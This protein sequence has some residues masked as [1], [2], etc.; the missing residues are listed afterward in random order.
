MIQSAAVIPYLPGLCRELL[1][2]DLALPSVPTRWA[3]SPEAH[4][5]A[6][7]LREPTVIKRALRFG[8]T[9]KPRFVHPSDRA[10]TEN[11]AQMLRE[12]PSAYVT[13]RQLTLSHAPIFSERGLEPRPMALRLFV[14]ASPDGY[15]VMP[16][17]LCRFAADVTSPSV[18]FAS[19]TGSKDVWVTSETPV[20]TFSL[21][22]RRPTPL[23]LQRG[24]FDLPSRVADNLYWLGRYVERAEGHARLL[25][26]AVSRYTDETGE[27][28]VPGLPALINALIQAKLIDGDQLPQ[29]HPQQPV[30]LP[31]QLDESLT[32][33][34]FEKNRPGSL[35]A[36]LAAVQRVASIVRDRLSRDASRMLGQVRDPVLAPHRG[37]VLELS[38]AA[39]TLDDLITRLAAFSG[40][41]MESMNRGMGW[42]FMDIGRRVERSTH[43]IELLRAA[44]VRLPPDPTPALEAVLEVADSTMTYRSRYRSALL[45]APVLDLLLIDETNPRSVAF[46]FRS[47]AD[48]VE[49]LPRD[50]ALPR[51][52]EE[53]RTIIRLLAATRL[54]DVEA[55]AE[56]D[57][58][59]GTLDDL[60]LLLADLEHHLPEFS[61]QL[62]R[63]YLSHAQPMHRIEPM[64]GVEG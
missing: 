56:P 39:S 10:A 42:R 24:G 31:T 57:G 23:M 53:Q 54:A 16:G 11:W 52:G 13:Q 7:A 63:R 44:L 62:S 17:G 2:E 1:G 22:K 20:D 47:I 26:A 15:T 38:D 12:H 4:D 25:R 34:I 18:S 8:H 3:A 50:P 45:P 49:L 51:Q 30:V 33:A 59:T 32:D 46:Q 43:L 27:L 60:D 41:C 9:D 19:D 40:V 28:G 36:T 14:A 58:D 48:H 61:A 35:H 5:P 6:E 21:L 64:G 29:A 55:L 37:G